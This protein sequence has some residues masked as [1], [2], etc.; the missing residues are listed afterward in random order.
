MKEDEFLILHLE[1]N[2][3]KVLFLLSRSN[4]KIPRT[5]PNNRP[6]RILK[7]QLSNNQ[8]K[9]K[10]LQVNQGHQTRNFSRKLR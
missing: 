3:K 2:K 7:P 1:E 8:K 9:R 6:K 10:N 4:S 5:N